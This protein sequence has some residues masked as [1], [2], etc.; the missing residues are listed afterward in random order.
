MM[1]DSLSMQSVE[2]DDKT[3]DRNIVKMYHCIDKLS[4]QNKTLIMLELEEIPQ[5]TIAETTG[6]AHGALRTR[7]SRIRKTLLK[8]ITNE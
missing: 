2:S 1:E 4:E 8:C 5:A 6:M 3:Y 7:L